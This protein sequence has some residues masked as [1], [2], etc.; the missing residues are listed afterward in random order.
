MGHSLPATTRYN[1][2]YLILDLNPVPKARKEILIS[3]IQIPKKYQIPKP[4]IIPSL[5]CVCNLVPG[6]YLFFGI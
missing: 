1:L 6:H 3:K 5:F 2:I 4:N